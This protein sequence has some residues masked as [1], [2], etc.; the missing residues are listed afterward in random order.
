MSLYQELK[1]RRV[2]HISGVYVAGAWLGAEIISFLLEQAMAPAWSFRLLAIVFVIGFPVAV[3][4]GWVVQVQE[5]GSW[6][7]DPSGGQKR[8]IIA[9]ITLGLLATAGLS[10]LILPDTQDKP[11]I[12]PYKPMSNSVAVLPFENLS[13][14]PEDAFFAAG[15]HT[16]ILSELAK[17]RDLSAIARASVMQYADSEKTIREI[18]EEL[19]VKTV[20]EGSV[21]YSADRVRITVQLI[22]PGTGAQLWSEN[23]DRDLADIFAIQT[24]IAIRIATA[25][26]AELLPAEK[27]RIEKPPTN[28]TAA[29]ALYLKALNAGSGGSMFGGTTAAQTSLSYLDQAIE[30][31]PGFAL[32]YVQKATMYLY[33]GAANQESLAEENL[34]KA[35]DLDPMLAI[36]HAYLGWAHLRSWRLEDARTAY[37]QAIKLA[38]NDP[39]VLEEYGTFNLYLGMHEEAIKTGQRI[40]ELNPASANSHSILGSA[41]LFAGET[42]L[43][44]DR[45]KRA[46]E[47]APASSFFHIQLA[48]AL[49]VGKNNDEA[50]TQLEIAEKLLPQ[51]ATGVVVIA[52][53]YSLLGRVEVAARLL[54]RFREIVAASGLNNPAFQV[55]AYLAAGETDLALKRLKTVAIDK[56]AL[57][58]G[59]MLQIFNVHNDPILEQPEFLKVRRRLGY[60]E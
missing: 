27:R 34:A 24:D 21:Q 39:L 5:D 60:P 29:W 1:R 56:E 47:I 3:V 54:P 48:S 40:L 30:L 23:Y 59:L 20:M 52:Y 9:A 31:D 44:I 6:A 28:S 42:E 33:A 43:A 25:L 19:N 17:I 58:Y 16:T 41:Y 18:A 35:L 45:L 36:A 13:L 50:E 22:N 8:T 55:W 46:S 32:A 11:S 7:L 10:W 37:A 12:Q 49:V 57:N 38:P 15:I 51:D 2:L 14:D 4:L 26:K 53:M